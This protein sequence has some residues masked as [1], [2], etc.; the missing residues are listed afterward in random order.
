M[1][2]LI[3][4]KRLPSQLLK[5]MQLQRAMPKR[6]QPQP[7]MP[8]SQQKQTQRNKK[9]N[10]KRKKKKRQQLRLHQPLL[11]SRNQL[12]KKKKLLLLPRKR[13]RLNKPRPKSMHQA[14]PRMTPIVSSKFT[15]TVVTPLNSQTLM[16]MKSPISKPR[17]SNRKLQAATTMINQTIK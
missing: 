16:T 5:R 7:P 8:R 6:K 14:R 1:P 3:R 13:M 15:R 4:N 9:L 10:Q 12:N 2:L 11:S 17:L